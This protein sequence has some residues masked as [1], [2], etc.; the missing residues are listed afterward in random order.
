MQ[1]TYHKQTKGRGKL[2]ALPAQTGLFSAEGFLADAA[3]RAG[4]IFRKVFPL[5][6]G[7]DAGIR[8]AVLFIV[9]PTANIANVFHCENHL[10]KIS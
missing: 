9:D 7:L 10:S 4:E 1:H 3:E 6:T 8:A 5:C 2:R